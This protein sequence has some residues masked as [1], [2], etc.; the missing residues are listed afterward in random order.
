MKTRRRLYLVAGVCNC[1]IGGL[2][3]LFGLLLLVLGTTIKTMFEKS[4]DL[5]SNFAK[6]LSQAD[7]EYAHLADASQEEILDFIFSVV[8]GFK[9]VV[10]IMSLIFI[11]FGVFNLLLRN[12]HDRVFEGRLWLKIIFVLVSWVVLILNIFNI[13]TTIAVFMK[14]PDFKKKDQ[15][16]VSSQET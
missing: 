1:I 6:E 16:Y 14:H 9:A 8:N 12:A 10:V 3:L 13:A 15:L 5:V 7:P 4:T 2:G 11:L